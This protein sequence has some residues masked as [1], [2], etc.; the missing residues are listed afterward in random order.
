MSDWK[1]I[2]V[3]T[4]RDIAEEYGYDQIVIIARKVGN[5][6]GEVCT[7]FGRDVENRNVAARI[8]DFLKFKIMGWVKERVLERENFC[9]TSS[10]C[11]D[12]VVKCANISAG[13]K[14]AW[15]DPKKCNARLQAL[16]CLSRANKAKVAQEISGSN[17]TY[18]EIGR[19]W[20]ITAARVSDIAKEF[21]IQRRR[22]KSGQKTRPVPSEDR[23][24]KSDAERSPEGVF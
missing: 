9:S 14:A 10:E 8:G 22:N 6:G 16:G 3:T 21:G 13:Q 11:S 12:Y 17:K 5:G 1:P 15:A 24:K 20:L 19:D 2:P 7:T 18:R 4:A 23:A